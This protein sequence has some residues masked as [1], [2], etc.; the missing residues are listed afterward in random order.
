MDADLEHG[1]KL[2]F[3]LLLDHG[4]RQLHYRWG[5]AIRKQ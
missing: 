1:I 3:A 4:W 2:W 5:W